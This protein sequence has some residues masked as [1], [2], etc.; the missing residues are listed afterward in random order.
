MADQ[1]QVVEAL[2]TYRQAGDI[3]G[4]SDRTIWSL[5]N[6]GHLKAVR[7]GRNVRITPADLRGFIEQAKG[8]ES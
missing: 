6:E 7:F 1:S 2:L 8:N 4:V 5:V 3:L